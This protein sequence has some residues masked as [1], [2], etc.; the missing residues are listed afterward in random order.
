MVSVILA[1]GQNTRFPYPKGLIVHKGKTI[2][3]SQISILNSLTKTV[4]ISTNQPELY[5]QL[6][7]PMVGDVVP[8]AG[9]MSGIL[10]ALKWSGADSVL[11]VA[12]DMPFIDKNLLHYML[13]HMAGD[14]TVCVNSNRPEPLIGIY[15]KSAAP[16]MERRLSEGNRS[17][18]GLL[19]EL[20]VRY[21]TGREVAGF[22]PEGLSFVNINTVEDFDRHI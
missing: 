8:P 21:I 15:F 1:G 3:E 18:A 11:V 4:I 19:D 14:A 17:M 12:C 22:D 2:I 20:N 9:P 16:V 13:E 6:G 10:S 7:I 5:F